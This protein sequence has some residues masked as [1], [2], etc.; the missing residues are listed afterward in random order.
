MHAHSDCCQPTSLDA[1]EQR[2]GKRQDAECETCEG[3]GEKKSGAM[4]RSNFSE[5]NGAGLRELVRKGLTGTDEIVEQ[6]SQRARERSNVIPRERARDGSD[7][8]LL[9]FAG[10]QSRLTG[11]QGRD[12]SDDQR[13]ARTFHVQPGH[14]LHPQGEYHRLRWAP[15]RTDAHRPRSGALQRRPRFQSIH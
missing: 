1:I 6:T 14:Q 7:S 2:E 8:L 4:P 9:V 12:D 13:D 11:Q 3:L 15:G 5:V 10:V